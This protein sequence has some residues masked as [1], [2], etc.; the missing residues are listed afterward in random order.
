MSERPGRPRKVR[1]GRSFSDG[2]SAFTSQ[3][4][5]LL[6]QRTRSQQG[7]SDV[8]TEPQVI[9]RVVFLVTSRH[10]QEGRSRIENPGAAPAK[11]RTG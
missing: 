9:A 2:D 6:A 3:E 7:L 11:R 4:A 8:I 10:R 5:R 1:R